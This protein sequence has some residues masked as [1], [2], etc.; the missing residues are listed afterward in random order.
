MV[1]DNPFRINEYMKPVA[2]LREVWLWILRVC[3]AA[4]QWA[5]LRAVN[6]EALLLIGRVLERERMPL[7]S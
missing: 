7:T 3:L 2:G 5:C 1:S 4:Q 6:K